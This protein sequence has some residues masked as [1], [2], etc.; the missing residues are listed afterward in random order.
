MMFP[1]NGEL[2]KAICDRNADCLD[3]F[4]KAQ[5]RDWANELTVVGIA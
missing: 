5:V 1:E 4:E 2:T 3:G